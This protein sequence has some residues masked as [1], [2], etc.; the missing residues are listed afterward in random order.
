VSERGLGQ[1]AELFAAAL[2]EAPEHRDAFVGAAC[3]GDDEL[4]RD[5]RELLAHH[6]Q[7]GEEFLSEPPVLSAPELEEEALP[8]T[9]GRYRLIERLG[10]GGMGAVYLAEQENPR[11]RVAL[12]LLRPGLAGGEMLARFA[13]EAQVLGRLS[14]PGI[15][16]I[17]EAA[18]AGTATGPQPYFAM[19]LVEGA[20]LTEYA[21]A[22]QLP[23]RRRVELLIDVCDAVHHAHQQGVVHR[24][25]KPANILVDEAGRPKV[26]DFG[27]ARAVGLDAPTTLRTRV[28]E[29]V[30]TLA[31]MSPEQ[32]A[33][34]PDLVDT[35]AD[36]WALGALGY[37]L[38][39]GRPPFVLDGLGLLESVRRVREEEPPA[40][41]D[42][43]R[44]LRGDLSTIFGKALEKERERR[45]SS[46][47]ALGDDLRRFLDDQPIAARPASSLYQLRKLARRNRPLVTSV[48][49]A[50]VLLSAAGAVTV[51][52]ALRLARE[53]DA[54]E[55]ARREAV[56][57]T[58][59]ATSVSAFLGDL[60]SSA[61]PGVGGKDASVAESLSKAIARVDE[62]FA[63]RPEH[64]AAVRA[65]LAKILYER[66]D[67]RAAG[68]VARVAYETLRDLPGADP[69]ALANSAALLGQSATA[70]GELDVAL[71]VLEG[72]LAL[73]EEGAVE[74]DELFG[75]VLENL[76][77]ALLAEE[78]YA[79][80]EPLLRRALEIRTALHGEGDARTLTSRNN[81]AILLLKSGRAAEAEP[82]LLA[83]LEAWERL[84]V[85]THPNAIT[86]AYNYAEVER[87]LGRFEAAQATFLEVLERG[88][89]GLPENHWL[90]SLHRSRYGELLLDLGRLDEAE[91]ILVESHAKLSR[92]LG[93]DHERTRRAAEA[94]ARLRRLRDEPGSAPERR[95][96][97]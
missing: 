94:L 7:A 32:A 89:R 20:P 25:L 36:V 12:K 96:A 85:P 91:P 78:R 13:Y 31:Y 11:R 14:H 47:A 1:T 92:L 43:A 57:Q 56:R 34:D 62:R 48:A 52:L 77:A 22:R 50:L 49:G 67:P 97:D 53:R 27:V 76:G 58:E 86:A 80:A 28:G 41:G 17:H 29:I 44:E 23:L 35:R 82:L 42:L 68:E 5:V 81:L 84:G 64:A 9:L 26:L 90:R 73:L 30:G 69:W 74:D 54:A 70:A 37:E 46:A 3:G 59:L 75:A 24:D 65:K 83:V 71:D 79:D 63:G 2:R 60:L 19:E 16:R 39:S 15:A 55:G 4:A 61:E 21:R 51:R 18:T 72:A 66:G 45:Y 38:L 8:R 87:Q 40:L 95:A 10:E 93:E 33:G 88:E 6:E